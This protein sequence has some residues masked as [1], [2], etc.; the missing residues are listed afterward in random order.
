MGVGTREQ[1]NM[2]EWV[3]SVGVGTRE[4]RNMREC[5]V[6]VCSVCVSVGVGMLC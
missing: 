2:R 6:N 3:C 4:Q 1:R 5:G